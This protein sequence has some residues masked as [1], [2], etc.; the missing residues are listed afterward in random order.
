MSELVIAVSNLYPLQYVLEST[1]VPA[2]SS[3]NY[4]AA[5]LKLDAVD[6]FIIM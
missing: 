3:S 2:I 1:L 4:M 5:V 6:L